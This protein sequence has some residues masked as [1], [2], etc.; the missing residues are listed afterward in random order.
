MTPGRLL[1]GIIGTTL[2]LRAGRGRLP[3]LAVATTARFA[4][5]GVSRVKHGP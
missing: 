2:A 4:S 3:T 1:R 5:S